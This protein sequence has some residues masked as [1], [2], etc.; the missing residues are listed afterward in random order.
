MVAR[1]FSQVGFLDRFQDLAAQGY[2]DWCARVL[3]VQFKGEVS[4]RFVSGEV[5]WRRLKI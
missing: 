3:G 1:I 5:G 4:K 2:R